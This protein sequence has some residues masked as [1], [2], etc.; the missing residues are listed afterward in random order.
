MGIVERFIDF[1]HWPVSRKIFLLGFM[2]VPATLVAAV[3]YTSSNTATTQSSVV[4]VGMVVPICSVYFVAQILITVVSFFAYRAGHIARGMAYVYVFVNA[5]FMATLTY[6]FGTMSSPFVAIFPTI[7]ILWVLY[8]DEGIA[9]FGFFMMLLMLTS[10]HILEVNGFIPYAP[11][12][13]NRMMDAQRSTAWFV[14]TF[15]AILI[16]FAFSFAVC[17]LVL[18][19]RRLQE[20]RLHQTRA[21]LERS[22]RLICRYVPAQLAEQIGAGIHAE[23]IK[24]ERRKLTIFFSEIEGF[25]EIAEELDAEELA[26]V[27]NEYLSDMVAIADKYSATVNQLVGDSI[28]IFFGAPHATN[29]K[30]HA[31]RAVR[32]ALDMQKRM[33]SL[34]NAW[35]ERGFQHPFRARIGI[36]TGYA[37]V[38][39]FGSEGR[40]LYSG[41]GVQTNLAARIQ[42]QCDPGA[43][44]VSHSTWALIRDEIPTEPKGELQV[45]G[46]HYPIR[47]YEIQLSD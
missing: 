10:I 26:S 21:L 24:P 1:T 25:T 15:I 41:I 3:M 42:S 4:D 46:V 28:M 5:L 6:L 39:D 12:L 34:Q 29:D 22:N 47:V 11:A 44:L 35:F 43:V 18:S 19:A 33:R 32:M 9:W 30:D 40:K 36:N 38:G 16:L 20:K 8:F 23:S 14:P 7:L 2:S 17:L 37:S 27:L 13:V 45:K 31:L